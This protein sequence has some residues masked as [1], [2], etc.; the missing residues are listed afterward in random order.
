MTLITKKNKFSNRLN[1]SP[2]T[3]QH[4]NA[5]NINNKLDSVS[6][7]DTLSNTTHNF[8]KLNTTIDP[9]AETTLSNIFCLLNRIERARYL[10]SFDDAVWLQI[11]LQE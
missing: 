4:A 11:D 7:G 5:L 8:E 1:K 9:P 10:N 6:A 3:T 2:T